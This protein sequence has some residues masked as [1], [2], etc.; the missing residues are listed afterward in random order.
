MLIWL[1]RGHQ[2]TA[3][4]VEACDGPKGLS[5]VSRA[6]IWAGVRESEREVIDTLFLSLTTYEIDARVAD[7]AGTF[8]RRYARQPTLELADA[9]IAATA[10]AHDLALATYNLAHFP[11]PELRL[12]WR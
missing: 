10:I 1:L 3:Q 9:L 6:E 8:L 12:A 11:M 5:V 4:R 7:L 2:A